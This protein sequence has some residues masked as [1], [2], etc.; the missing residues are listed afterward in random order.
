VQDYSPSEKEDQNIIVSENEGDLKSHIP[1]IEI[2]FA[3]GQRIRDV[4]DKVVLKVSTTVTS[5]TNKVE[6]DL[7]YS[8]S[9]DLGLKLS[10][11]LAALSFSFQNDHSKKPLF[12]PRIATFSCATCD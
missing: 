1:L 3:D 11:E 6:V 5:K 7:W 8:T 2:S 10:D 9:L 4:Q 12:T